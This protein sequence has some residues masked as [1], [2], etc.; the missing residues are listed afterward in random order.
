MSDDVTFLS[1][2]VRDSMESQAQET[3]MKSSINR[4]LDAMTNLQVFHSYSFGLSLNYE[5]CESKT[6]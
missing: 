2:I 6:R 1:Q 5:T 3:M 4:D